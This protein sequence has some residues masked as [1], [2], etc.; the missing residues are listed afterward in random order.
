MD[1][2]AQLS[3]DDC[4]NCKFY[5]GPCKASLFIRD[6]SDC[7]LAVMCQQFRTRDCKRIT[8]FLLCATQPI[9]ESSISMKFGC[10]SVNYNGL[11][12]I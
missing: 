3:I 10:I 5:I 9:I 11:D 7:S 4:T 8:S 12:G 6:C 1:N 2:L